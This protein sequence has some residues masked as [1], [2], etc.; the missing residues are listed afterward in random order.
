MYNESETIINNPFGNGNHTISSH[1][2]PR[3]WKSLTGSL[4]SLSSSSSSAAKPTT[5]KNGDGWEL[6]MIGLPTLF[7]YI[8]LILQSYYNIFHYIHNISYFQYIYIYISIS[9]Y[10]YIL[11]DPNVH[12]LLLHIPSGYLT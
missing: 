2:L 10:I 6:V 8:Y 7:I 1:H 11:L 4:S 12:D 9:I 5:F 3:F